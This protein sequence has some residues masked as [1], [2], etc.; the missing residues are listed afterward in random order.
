MKP[1]VVNTSTGVY[2]PCV[3]SYEKPVVK[4]LSYEDSRQGKVSEESV[5]KHTVQHT[6]VDT[7]GLSSLRYRTIPVYAC[8]PAAFGNAI[9]SYI[10]H[11][12]AQKPY[13]PSAAVPLSQDI[14][15]KMYN[16][17][18]AKEKKLYNNTDVPLDRFDIMFLVQSVFHQK[19]VFSGRSIAGAKLELTRWDASKLPTLE[20]VVLG[21]AEECR[22]HESEKLEG[23]DPNKVT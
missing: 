8:V 17:F 18:L 7:T 10:L 12:L 1:M 4:I 23:L 19:S 16:S 14:V 20:N 3:S 2:I 13:R 15:L 6:D 9:C 22:K 21:T 5:M 11:S